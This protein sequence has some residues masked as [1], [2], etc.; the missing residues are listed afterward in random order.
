[1][2]TPIR[3]CGSQANIQYSLYYVPTGAAIK[4]IVGTGNALNFGPQFF[5][6]SYRIMAKNIKTGCQVEMSNRAYYGSS[7]SPRMG[8]EDESNESD[9]VSIGENPVR[10]VL[11]VRFRGE[12]GQKVNLVLS[13]IQGRI[14]TNRDVTLLYGIDSAE[15]NMVGSAMGSYILNVQQNEKIKRFTIL[16]AQ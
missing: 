3:T 16:K 8:V 2:T 7:A 1:M 11:K 15:I 14:L 9:W 12:V 13:D 10:D 6:G 5:P 4:T